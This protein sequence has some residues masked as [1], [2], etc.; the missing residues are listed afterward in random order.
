M[1]LRGIEENEIV[2]TVEAGELIDTVSNRFVRRCVFTEGYRWHG[3]EY[4][5]KEVTVVYV[6]EGQRS[7]IL[8]AIAR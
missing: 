2:D 6:T 4:L 7:V 8:T 1:R 5:H 3:R